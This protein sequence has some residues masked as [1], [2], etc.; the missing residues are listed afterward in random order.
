MRKY[1]VISGDGHVEVPSENWASYMPAKYVDLMPKLIKREGGDYWQMDEFELE[2]WGNLVC[3]LPYDEITPGCWR[4]F[5]PDGSPRPGTGSAAQRLNEQ[6]FDGLDAE[7]LFPPIHGPKFIRL[8]AK[9]TPRM[10]PALLS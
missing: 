6:D 9:R 4:Y 5:N 2:N 8:M 3:D 1:E 10:N 7:V